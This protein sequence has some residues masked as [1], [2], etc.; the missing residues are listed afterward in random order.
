MSTQRTY[1]TKST[2]I[3]NVSNPDGS[4]S[5]SMTDEGTQ[6]S[7]G[8][9]NKAS[10]SNYSPKESPNLFNKLLI[11][12]HSSKESPN[13]FDKPLTDNSSPKENST[14]SSEDKIPVIAIIN[15]H[16]KE[17]YVTRG[18][19]LEITLDT[20]VYIINTVNV[21]LS[22]NG[23]ELRPSQKS[24]Q[25]TQRGETFGPACIW[26]LSSR[27]QNLKASLQF[28]NGTFH[29]KCNEDCIILGVFINNFS[30]M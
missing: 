24:G 8:S 10:T 18:K 29:A 4:V 6:I 26:V 22:V 25:M 23:E 1:F 11:D 3:G 5:I 13:L 17:F 28:K 14:L 19:M 27:N 2:N 12:N 30:S 20:D 21:S 9:F 16:S 15:G 7:F